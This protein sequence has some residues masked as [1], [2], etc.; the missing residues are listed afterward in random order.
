M[1]SDHKVMHKEEQVLDQEE[2]GVDREGNLLWLSTTKMPLYDTGGKVVG[3][4]GLSED[5]TE[6]KH[7]EE[8]LRHYAE[9]MERSNKELEEFASIASHDLQEPLRKIMA[10]GHRLKTTCG[11]ALGEQGSDYLE[12]ME[13][14]AERMQTLISDLLTLSRVT[15]RRGRSSRWTWGRS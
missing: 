13:N 8:R 7:A 12:R 5:I 2:P 14:A 10:F 6:R 3:L 15:S 9:Q 1:E 11:A 4:V